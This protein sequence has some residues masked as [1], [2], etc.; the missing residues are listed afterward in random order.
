MYFFVEVQAMKRKLAPEEKII[1]FA[2][3]MEL[4]G[5][6]ISERYPELFKLMHIALLLLVTSVDPERAFSTMNMLKDD[7]RNRLSWPPAAVT[8]RLKRAVPSCLPHYFRTYSALILPAPHPA[9]CPTR[10]A[11]EYFGIRVR[12][13]STGLGDMSTDFC[14][15]SKEL[16]RIASTS[17]A[18]QNLP[19]TM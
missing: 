2:D 17:T 19:R 10:T 5:D 18:P 14:D 9:T 12:H 7:T 3:W 11:Q 4:K 15:R 13:L 1:D 6:I 8:G 16:V